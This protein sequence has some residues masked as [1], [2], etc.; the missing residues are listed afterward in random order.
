MN[1]ATMRHG[2]P[3]TCG[4][5]RSSRLGRG[6]EDPPCTGALLCHVAAYRCHGRSHRTSALEARQLNS[7][8]R[9][10]IVRLLRQIEHGEGGYCIACDRMPSEPGHKFDCELAAILRELEGNK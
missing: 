8:L 1:S 6:S 9:E 7:E 5:G 2:T 4:L 3:I 10:R